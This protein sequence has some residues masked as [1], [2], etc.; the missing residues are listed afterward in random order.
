MNI[1]TQNNNLVILNSEE[2]CLD[3][4]KLILNKSQEGFESDN[5]AEIISATCAYIKKLEYCLQI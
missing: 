3:M 4:L 2:D 1:E 5:E